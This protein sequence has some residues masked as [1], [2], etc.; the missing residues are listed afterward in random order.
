MADIKFLTYGETRRGMKVN[1]YDYQGNF[2]T[3]GEIVDRFESF[4]FGNAIAMGEDGREHNIYWDEK[5]K[6]VEKIED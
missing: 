3:K 6:Q 4:G 1:I 2:V 5:S